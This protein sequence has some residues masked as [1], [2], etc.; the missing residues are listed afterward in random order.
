M[1]ATNPWIYDPK[2]A[3]GRE[4]DGDRVYIC[5][6][7]VHPP[8]GCVPVHAIVLN[9]EF[10]VLF[11]MESCSCVMVHV[12]IVLELDRPGSKFTS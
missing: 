11:N 2:E 8:D 1:H 9:L 10:L 5:T 4:T 12:L 6:N 7:C 3:H